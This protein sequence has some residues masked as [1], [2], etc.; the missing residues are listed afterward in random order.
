[1]LKVKIIALYGGD[2]LCRYNT[3][4]NYSRKMGEE[5]KWISMIA[6]LQ[7]FKQQSTTLSRLSKVKDTYYKP[8]NHHLNKNTKR[9][10]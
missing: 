7:F 10:A 1:M 4:D 2:T 6:R 8:Q 9:Y 5:D 3:Y